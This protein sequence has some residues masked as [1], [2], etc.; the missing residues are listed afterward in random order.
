LHSSTEHTVSKGELGTVLYYAGIQR[1]T[2]A[3][4]A[5]LS[6]GRLLLCNLSDAVCVLLLTLFP[7]TTI[8]GTDL[9]CHFASPADW[10]EESLP[11]SVVGCVQ[12]NI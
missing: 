12:T 6:H 8:Y 7:D 11:T 5:S 3:R 9:T 1:T 4:R 10:H 2:T